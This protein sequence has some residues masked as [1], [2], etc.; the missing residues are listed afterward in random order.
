MTDSGNGPA[1][2]SL[3]GLLLVV[4]L[5]LACGGLLEMAL[6]V[7]APAWAVG[8][9]P[10]AALATIVLY[11]WAVFLP[12]RRLRRKSLDFRDNTQR[13][14]AALRSSLAALRAGDLVSAGTHGRDLGHDFEM[15]VRVALKSLDGLVRQIQGGS[16][17]VAVAAQKVEQTASDLASGSSQQAAGVVEITS[18]MEELA[19][20]AGQIATNAS[21]QAQLSADAERA[22]DEGAGAVEEALSGM[23]AVRERMEAIASRTDALGRRSREIFAPICLLSRRKTGFFQR[24][25]DRLPCL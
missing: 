6:P 8:G 1:D 2:R 10:V 19:R 12:E 24:V 4:V 7:E 21:T 16:I 22:G 20:A 15:P 14:L 13:Q 18:T 9:I 17:E 25:K 11:L 3:L 5:T 23:E